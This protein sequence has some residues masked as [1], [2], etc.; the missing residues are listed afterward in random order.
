[1]SIFRPRNSENI[2][3]KY[4]AACFAAAR[5]KAADMAAVYGQTIG[6]PLQIDENPDGGPFYQY[7]SWC[8][9]GGE[10]DYGTSNSSVNV[11]A[12]PGVK[13]DTVALGKI[14]VPPERQRCV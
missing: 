12:N 3:T 10:R 9:W 14:A 5:E 2:A 1:M 11:P 7:W 6:K 13:M 8:G 4:A